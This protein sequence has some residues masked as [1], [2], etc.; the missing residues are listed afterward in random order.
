MTLA[1]E[2]ALYG[3]AD[4][5]SILSMSRSVIYE[6]IR[7]GRLEAV[8]QG[9]RATSPQRPLS[10]TSDCLNQKPA[11]MAARRSRG[12]GG[13]HFSERRQRWIAT[14]HVGF[15]ASGRRIVK[16]A[17]GKTRTEAKNRLREIIRDLD[18]GLGVQGHKFAVEDALRD[19][20]AHGLSGRDPGTIATHRHLIEGH[21]IPGL[22]RRRLRELSADD[23]DRWLAEEATK[24]STST[25]SKMLSILRRAIKRQMSRDRVKRN[26]AL[27]CELPTGQP[28]RPSKS[29]TLEQA[30]ALLTAAEGSDLYAYV[31]L[32]LLTGARTEELR[33]LTWAN[34][35]LEG[36]P[37][38]TPLLPPTVQLWRS[39]RSTGDTKT[40]LSRRTLRLPVRCIDAHTA[41]RVAQTERRERAEGRWQDSDL[42]FTTHIGTQLDSSN[43]RRSFRRVV[44]EAGLDPA[45]W[46]PRELRH[47][48]VSLMSDAGVPLEEIA[49]L[50]G[51]RGTVV[52]EAVYRKQL[53]PV[54]TQGAETMDRI[55]T[56]EDIQARPEAD[57]GP[58]SDAKSDP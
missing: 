38:L 44:K 32:S 27:L 9:R 39:V 23:V 45:E 41:H 25:L 49:R 52:T 47:S 15:S 1:P 42:V 22:G 33:A 43:V 51:H 35:D 7:S 54:I 56:S 2:R 5:V 46:T 13:V 58:D 18:D 31:T 20:L 29:M 40:K 24:V 11:S 19:W 37:D 17:S 6:Q 26:V 16:R 28:G 53:R 50:V 4:A 3:I 34:V 8:H 21:L 48:F 10:V 36:N 55:F 30:K 12:D 14:A 57:S